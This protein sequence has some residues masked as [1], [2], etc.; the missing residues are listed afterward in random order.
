MGSRMFVGQKYGATAVR[1]TQRP[2]TPHKSKHMLKEKRQDSQE[3]Q[4]RQ[5]LTTKTNTRR[6]RNKKRTGENTRETT[7]EHKRETQEAKTRTDWM[8]P[9]NLSST[10]PWGS[11]LRL[12][13]LRSGCTV[14]GTPNQRTGS[15]GTTR[16]VYR[17]YIYIYIYEAVGQK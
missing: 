1:A 10:G 12:S 17:Y 4:E 5:T 11:R 6:K 2:R 8:A 3:Q 7:K 15:S 14:A 16:C 9:V 13:C